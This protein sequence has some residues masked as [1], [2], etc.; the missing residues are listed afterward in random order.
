MGYNPKDHFFHKAKQEGFVAR[1]AYKL[2]EIQKKYKVLKPGQRVLDLGCSPGSWS[3]VASKLIG[4]RGQLVGIDLK[5]VSVQLQNADFR[6]VDVLT[7]ESKDFDGLF[8]CILSDMAPNT[9]GIRVRDQ[10]LS[11]ELCRMAL[12]LSE[13]LLKPQ[14]HLVM[15]IFEGPDAQK[16]VNDVKTKFK[17]VD[18]LKPQAVRKGSFEIYIVALEKK[19]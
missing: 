14:G 1:S 13:K 4:P 8:D 2:E 7:L 6:M 3:Q 19:S 5:P 16:L 9:S 10:A 12:N 15:K 18:R 11:E 17:K